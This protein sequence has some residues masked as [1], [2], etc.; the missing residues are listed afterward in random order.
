MRRYHTGVPIDESRVLRKLNED[1]YEA[2]RDGRPPHVVTRLLS[3][4][5]YAMRPS[6][7]SGHGDRGAYVYG[8]QRVWIAIAMYSAEVLG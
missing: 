5:S 6:S 8:V 4:A 2:M 1:V 3:D 7:P